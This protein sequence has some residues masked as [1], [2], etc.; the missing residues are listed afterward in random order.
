MQLMPRNTALLSHTSVY[1]QSRPLGG[2]R[3]TKRQLLQLELRS[4]LEK[5]RLIA[6][7]FYVV[8]GLAAEQGDLHLLR[9]RV[10]ESV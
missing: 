8:N 2:S 9:R 1:K 5:L 10:T 7:S 6:S 3:L 4:K